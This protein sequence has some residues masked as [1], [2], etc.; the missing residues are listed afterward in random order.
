MTSMSC[1]PS[2]IDTL[3]CADDLPA[4]L[5]VEL[6][7]RGA[8]RRDGLRFA[9]ELSYGRH[10]GPAPADARPAAVIALLFQRN[11]RWHIPLTVRHVELGRHGGQIS[12]PG[13][14]IDAGE[15]SAD[16]ARRELSEELGAID[17]VEL[18]GELPECYVYVSNFRVRPWL[19]VT[20]AEPSW[21]PHDCEVERVVEMP[22]EV[23][24]DP[25]H[26]GTVTIERGPVAFRAPCYCIGED[27]VWG[28]TSI[29]LGRL[30]GVLRR[31]SEG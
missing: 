31:I 27:C 19:A 11:G 23:L 4:Q 15:S 29:I 22:L 20:P 28:A 9:P 8:D 26:I 21:R 13:G 2:K 1:M 30:A 6:E 7:T 16:A 24:L 12:L 10:F 3:L 18:I 14:A 5:A 17:S 25:S